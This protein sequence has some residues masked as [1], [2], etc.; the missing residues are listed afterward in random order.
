MT[1]FFKGVFIFNSNFILYAKTLRST[2]LTL[3]HQNETI[4]KF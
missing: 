1:P 3:H 4:L 2:Y